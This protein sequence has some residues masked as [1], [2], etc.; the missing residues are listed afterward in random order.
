MI[1]TW[2]IFILILSV[3]ILVH[4]FGHFIIAKKLGVRVEQFSLGFGKILFKKKKQDTEYSIGIMPLGGFVKLAGDNLDEYK[5][6]PDEYYSQAPGR[7]FWIIFFGPLLNYILGFLLFWFIFFSGYPTLTTK[8]GGL[9]D[10]FCAKAAGLE[11]GDKI[12]AVDSKRVEYWEDL[13]KL[14]QSDKSGS[15]KLAIIRKDKKITVDV[16]IKGKE[17]Q[18]SIGQKRNFNLIGII[19]FDEIV[20]VRH[21][22]LESVSLGF[23]KTAQLTVMTYKALGYLITGKLSM[24]DSMSGPLGIF[25]I[26]S[27]AAKLGMIAVL[28]LVAVLSLSLAIFNLLPLPILDGGHI[29][30]LGLEKIRGKPLGIRS[31]QVINKIGITFIMTLA[32]FVTYNDIVKHFGSQITK[33]FVK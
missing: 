11:V 7:R 25:F 10:G 3:L 13:Q 5:G 18:D 14:I 8:V 24:R 4:E 28:H 32:I 20:I 23:Q 2:I 27:K 33:F 17:L 9:I 21:G 26:T 1:L 15:V 6:K 31:E 19:P 30:L 22:F 16:K 29:L 12:T